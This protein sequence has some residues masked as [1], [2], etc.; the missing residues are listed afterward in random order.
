MGFQRRVVDIVARKPEDHHV[1]IYT[2]DTMDN[3]KLAEKKQVPSLVCDRCGRDITDGE[4][5]KAVTLWR[6]QVEPALWE[7]NFNMPILHE[8]K[9]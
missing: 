4:P 7:V 9:H 2:G 6:G 1:K 5:C 3:L 8:S